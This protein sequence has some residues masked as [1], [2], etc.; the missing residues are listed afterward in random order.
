M[1]HLFVLAI[2][3]TGSLAFAKHT[4]FHCEGHFD[5]KG[6]LK[7]EVAEDGLMATGTFVDK[8]N[9]KVD[10]ECVGQPGISKKDKLYFKTEKNEKCPADYFRVPATIED[11]D[12]SDIAF[13]NTTAGDT[14]D[15]SGYVYQ[16][17]HC[18]HETVK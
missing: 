3:T 14:H 12:E 18:A 5:T 4:P 6:Q 17:F 11:D 10:F 7:I 2:L 16:Y 13:V 15:W 8:S 1:K 9:N